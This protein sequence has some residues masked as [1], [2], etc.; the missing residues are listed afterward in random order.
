[1]LQ[2]NSSGEIVVVD[3]I[4]V[5]TGPNT[6]SRVEDPL[7]QTES[8]R[9][10]TH[11]V[12]NFHPSSIPLTVC[13]LYG[14]LGASPDQPMASKMPEVYVTYTIPLDHLTWYYP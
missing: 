5:P 11:T 2:M 4:E 1:M 13:D 9:T 8:F 14:N 12:E 7:F 6:G 10:P 3:N